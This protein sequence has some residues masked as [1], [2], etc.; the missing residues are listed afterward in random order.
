MEE[1]VPLNWEAYNSFTSVNSDHRSVSAKI[2]LSL[3]MHKN[4]G[5]KKVNYNWNELLSDNNIKSEYSVDVRNRFEALQASS[6]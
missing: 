4:N 5:R 2:R 3:R 6:G 1:T